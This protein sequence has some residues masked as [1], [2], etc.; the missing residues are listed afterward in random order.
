[1]SVDCTSVTLTLY[2]PQTE[3]KEVRDS[4]FAWP[5]RVVPLIAADI[6]IENVERLVSVLNERVYTQLCDLGETEINSHFRSS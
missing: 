5:A 3:L 1:M 4:W 2:Q 6:S